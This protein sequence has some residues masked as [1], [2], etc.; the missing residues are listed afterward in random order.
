MLKFSD[1]LKKLLGAAANKKE[2]LVIASKNPK[3]ITYEH[4]P[5]IVHRQFTDLVI[6]STDT[7]T[8]KDSDTASTEESRLGD[9]IKAASEADIEKLRNQMQEAMSK[10]K[11]S[12]ALEETEFDMEAIK[13][14]PL[15]HPTL[16]EINLLVDCIVRGIHPRDGEAE[17]KE[18]N[19]LVILGYVT[20]IVY[21]QSI[22]HFAVT[23]RG[24]RFILELYGTKTIREAIRK[25]RRFSKIIENPN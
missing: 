14:L 13:R 3:E 20:E 5:G 12:D 19:E 6:V 7:E 1:K 21:R 11:A 23:A 22:N 2:W 15:F 18:I 4:S 16:P 17:R 8:P 24:Y 9:A 10:D 25:N